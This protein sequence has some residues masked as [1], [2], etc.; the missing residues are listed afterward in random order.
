MGWQMTIKNMCIN[1]TKRICLDDKYIRKGLLCDRAQVYV[2]RNTVKSFYKT[3]TWDLSIIECFNDSADHNRHKRLHTVQEVGST[4]D[5][6][7]SGLKPIEVIVLRLF[8]V[9][10]LTYGEIAR[11]LSGPGKRFNKK[12]IS[13]ILYQARK[14]NKEAVET[15]D[16]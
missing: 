12:K 15:V 14:R 11:H 16:I 4:I 8:E 5:V 10:G 9:Q 3:D 2:D 7:T 1:C 6:D 13:N